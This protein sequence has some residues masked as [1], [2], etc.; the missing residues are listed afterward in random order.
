MLTFKFVVS[1]FHNSPK[2]LGKC[3]LG[4]SLVCL[5]EQHA[6]VLGTLKLPQSFSVL[7]YI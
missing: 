3:S 6:A 2:L 4:I 5:C 7:Y 1:S